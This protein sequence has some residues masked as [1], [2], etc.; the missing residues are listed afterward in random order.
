MD[1]NEFIEELLTELSYRSKKGY[2]DFN[3]SDHIQLMAEILDDWG[4]TEIKDEL[5][6][7]IISEA[8]EDK[9][10]TTFENP[11]LN[12]EVEYEDSE[13][14]RKTGKVGNLL[15]QPENTPPREAAEAEL[16]SL[17]DEER[18]E[19]DNELGSQRGNDTDPDMDFGDDDDN[20]MSG[21]QGNGQPE[22]GTSVNPDSEAGQDYIDSLSDD[23]PAKKAAKKKKGDDDGDE[24]EEVSE[25]EQLSQKDNEITDSQLYMT[26]TEAKKQAKQKGSKDVGAGT[27][28]SRAGEALVHR[29]LREIQSGKSVDEV[30]EYFTKLV[31]QKDH[32]L[33]SRDGKKWVDS[34]IASINIID[35]SIGIDN[36]ETVSWDTSQGR[37]AIGVSESLET[38]SDMFVRTKEG[39]N[40]GVSMKKT[41]KVFLNNG[42][43]KKQ[44]KKLLD[45]LQNEMPED[46]HKT[47]TEAM[48]IEAYKEDL[49]NRFNEVAEEIDA[50]AVAESFQRLMDEDEKERNRLFGGSKQD[51]Y[52]EALKNPKSLVKKIKLGTAYNYEQKAYSKLLQMYHKD[53]YQYLRDA[54]NG[55]TQRA[56]DALNQSPTAKLGMNKHIIKSMHISETLGL[57]EDVKEGGVDKFITTYGIEPDGAVLDERTLITLFGS[58]FKRKLDEWVNEVRAG[59]EDYEGFEKFISDQIT[60]DYDTGQIMFQHESNQ[61]FPLFYMTGR[62]RGIGSS[63]VM[64]MAQTPFMA[65][66]LKMG[67][68]NTDEWPEESYKKFEDD[69][70]NT[71][72]DSEED[73]E[74]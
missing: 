18:D 17:S 68:F 74:E 70:I 34:A 26:K 57:N 10:E 63:P 5:I 37:K 64:E 13:G 31:N 55:L 12:K 28:E 42:G 19:I 61:K 62:A 50:E 21:D 33:N 52:F 73:D 43:W 65:H 3:D 47:L 39:E 11:I 15:R 40:I 22:T 2:P 20:E 36:V 35:D 23:D 38:S 7:N 41:G 56:F 67:T 71:E 8:P 59:N 72:K 48:S 27:P 1:K 44:S 69:I 51:K 25:K 4:L 53:K 60:I 46:D 54:D 14:N 29:G 24:G 66:A 9:E 49:D 30:K 16:G 58:D 6:N 45:S 32:I